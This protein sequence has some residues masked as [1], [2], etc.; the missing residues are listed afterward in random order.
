MIFFKSE[1]IERLFNHI[2]KFN[3]INKKS[4]RI[5]TALS[6]VSILLLVVSQIGLNHEATRTFFTNID[7]YEGVGAENIEEMFKTGELTIEL[8][9]IEPSEKIK[10]LVNGM[11]VKPFRNK[12][13]V[14]SIRNN[15]VIEIDGTDIKVP[16]RVRVEDASE[17]LSENVVGKE[18]NINSNIAVLA[19][20][21]IK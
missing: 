3:I 4:E 2:G 15:C 9:D 21:F 7:Q 13:E 8:L 1:K 19:R 12:T 10:I 6:I 16:F 14:I 18:V 11:E 17:N 20:V 5:L